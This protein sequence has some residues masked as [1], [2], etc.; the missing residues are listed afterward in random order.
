M[1]P[2]T[3]GSCIVALTLTALAVSTA[4]DAAAQEVM[5]ERKAAHTAA[6]NE[7]VAWAG[8]TAE[9]VNIGLT[10]REYTIV[11]VAMFEA[12]NAVTQR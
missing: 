5:E 3:I 11:T 1:R 10:A 12:A 8:H 7:A 2:H 6:A 4:G 9:L